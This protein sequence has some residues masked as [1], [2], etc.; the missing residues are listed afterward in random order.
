MHQIHGQCYCG[1]IQ[2]ACDGD[3]LFT[4]YCHCQKC[5]DVAALSQRETDQQGYAFTAAYLTTH[6]H[7]TYGASDLDEIIK[8]NAKLFLC[9]QC[10]S[11]IYGIAIDPAKQGGIGINA[12]NFPSDALQSAAFQPVRHVWYANRIVTFQDDLPK[13]KDAPVDQMGT[14]ELM[15]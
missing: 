10:H 2:F 4:Q 9:C 12:R 13:F 7:V 3:P 1:A 14:G 6:F 5:R 15:N 11:L 8:N